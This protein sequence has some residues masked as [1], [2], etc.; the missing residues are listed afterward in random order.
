MKFLFM[1]NGTNIKTVSSRLGHTN[2]TTTNR[3]VHALNDADVSAA[4]LL[5][6]KFEN[7]KEGQ[8]WDKAL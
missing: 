8:E 5:G 2:L 1:A 3:Y 7:T 6:N 4:A